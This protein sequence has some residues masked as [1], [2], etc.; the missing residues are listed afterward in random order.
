M[1]SVKIELMLMVHLWLSAPT[2]FAR[3]P[4]LWLGGLCLLGDRPWKDLEVFFF[5][6]DHT[7]SNTPQNSQ[8][9]VKRSH[10]AATCNPYSI[11]LL[12]PHPWTCVC[13]NMSGRWWS[14]ST[15]RFWVSLFSDKA[16][17]WQSTASPALLHQKMVCKP[18][19]RQQAKGWNGW[20]GQ[21][22][23]REPLNL[24][25]PFWPGGRETLLEGTFSE[26]RGSQ[27]PRQKKYE[28]S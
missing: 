12:Q 1:L 23:D 20:T 27:S 28:P 26:A 9:A 5:R 25:T 15:V 8:P 3:P 10:T 6:T 13:P 4:D 19:L 11:F 18:C 21:V 16:I 7:A 24:K 14:T 17:D 22:F 2:K